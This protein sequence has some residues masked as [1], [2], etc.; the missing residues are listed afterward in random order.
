VEGGGERDQVDAVVDFWLQENPALDPR[1]KT[2]AI[3]LR[4]VGHHLER[5]LRQELAANDIEM[6]EIEVLFALR[7]GAGHCRSVSDLLRAS[8][9]TSG[10]VTNRVARL[11][12]RGWV[13]RDIDPSDRR[14]V[15]VTL[16]PEGLV[17]ADQLL[18]TRTHAEE[19][20]FGGIP[21]E[22]Q[23]RLNNDLRT[24]LIALE[25]LAAPGDAT[26]QPGRAGCPL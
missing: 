3:R 16:T 4:R 21:V 23:D 1:M 6:W 19:L 15:L 14:H 25:G 5:V 12:E 26:S 24:L 2:L 13:R 20:F 9:V 17:R 7:R 8:Q 11:E 18:A 22:V 10:A